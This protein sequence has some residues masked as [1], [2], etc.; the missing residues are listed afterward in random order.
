MKNQFPRILLLISSL[1]LTVIISCE[2]YTPV[3]SAD[4]IPDKGS[5]TIYTPYNWSH[6]GEPYQTTYCTVYS[7]AAGNEMKS[8]MGEI[9]DESFYKIMQLF[10]FQ[11]P[12]DFRYPPG[13]SNIEIYLNINH[14]E[15]INWAYWGGFIITIKSDEISG[16]WI[17]YTLYTTRHEL[18]HVFEFLI[19]GKEVLGTDFWFREGMA[20][21][22]GCL[23]SSIFNTIETLNELELWI[24]ENQNS[25]G[26]GNPVAVHQ[27][28]DL[29][30]GADLDKYY[31]V[32]ELAL[33][34]ILDDKG[35]GKSYKDIKNLFYE[36]RNG[37][38][39]TSAFQKN[40]GISLKYYENNFYDLMAAYLSD[41]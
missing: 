33:R 8:D 3:E 21:H 41:E 13:Y 25:P 36:I 29:P 9:A 28:S 1:F 11:N 30:V 27:Y 35:F 20:V 14:T 19:E 10:T 32:F 39:F 26:K 22:T 24:S 23:E 16:P 15:N 5:W 4:N 6:D 2:D 12:A 18:T 40:L 34:Y 31:R 7:D 37:T 17:D 38:P